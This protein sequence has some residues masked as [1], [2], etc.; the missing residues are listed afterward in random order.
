MAVAKEAAHE[1][2]DIA[3]R[4]FE[5]FI[6]NDRRYIRNDGPPNWNS[7]KQKW[8]LNVT[9]R[10][11][12]VTPALW[13]QHLVGAYILSVIPL[14]DDNTCWFGCI[15][16][17]DY[18][19]NIIELCHKIDD[20]KLPLIL[21]R[22]KSGGP[23]LFLFCK[24]PVRAAQLIKV[25]HY[26]A[27]KLGLKKYEIFPSSATVEPGKFS[28]GIAM[29]YGPTWDKTEEQTGMHGHGGALTQN[30]FV[31]KA[32]AARI[33][34]RELSELLPRE[35]SSSTREIPLY[36]RGAIGWPEERILL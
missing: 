26:L 2:P 20:W 9:T 3:E 15:D 10:D 31:D 28:R 24:E 17:D 6:G 4:L 22:S 12:P 14:L 32:E 8:E 29:P 5:L 30:Q 13:R 21:V 35:S 27:K 16:G 25:L 23:H 7:T 36:M 11:E 19:T 1:V 18:E 33:T 34:A